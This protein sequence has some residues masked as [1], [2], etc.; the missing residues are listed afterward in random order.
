[1]N[2]Q[3]EFYES[4]QKNDIENVKILLKNKYVKPSDCDNIAIIYTYQRG[5]SL[6][7]SILWNNAIIKKT[8]EKDCRNLYNILI[9]N[10][11]KNKLDEF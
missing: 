6:I 3:K 9:K 2:K 5:L 11:L 4:V 1:M 7:T 8:L 10:D